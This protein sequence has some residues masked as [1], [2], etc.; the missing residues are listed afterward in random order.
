MFGQFGKALKFGAYA[1]FGVNKDKLKDLLLFYS[2]SHGK[3]VTLR[4]CVDGLKNIVPIDDAERKTK[5]PILYACGET[6]EKISMLPQLELAHE[7]GDD[8][9]YFT[10]PVDEFIARMLVSYDGHKFENV[11][12]GDVKDDD[13]P[14]GSEGLLRRIEAKLK[15]KASVEIG[16]AHV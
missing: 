12:S 7:R 1:D 13:R 6:T 15:G 4:E 16:R 10:E 8:V 2:D 5:A 11:A 14:R 9:L 3:L